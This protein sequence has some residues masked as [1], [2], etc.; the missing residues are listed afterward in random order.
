VMYQYLGAYRW[1]TDKLYA[2]PEH[3]EQLALLHHVTA[4]DIVPYDETVPF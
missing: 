1:A 3:V 4:S 2:C